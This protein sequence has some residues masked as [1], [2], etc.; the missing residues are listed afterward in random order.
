M[1]EHLSKM[2]NEPSINLGPL[3]ENDEKRINALIDQYQ[4]QLKAA[5]SVSVYTPAA[6]VTGAL[7]NISA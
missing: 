5:Q 1:I 6:P 2:K 4:K 3:N 7:F